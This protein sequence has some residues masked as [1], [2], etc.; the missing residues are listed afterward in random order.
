MPQERFANSGSYFQ[1]I[2]GTVS[3]DTVSYGWA[4]PNDPILKLITQCK[5]RDSNAKD[6]MQ[7]GA[8]GKRDWIRKEG[9]LRDS[10][11]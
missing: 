6:F 1:T 11:V 7:N 5:V 3:K 9:T 2:C 4:I 10:N 8:F